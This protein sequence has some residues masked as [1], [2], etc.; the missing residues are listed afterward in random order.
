MTEPVR[1]RP[2]A[3]AGYGYSKKP[4]GMLDWS[5]VEAALA[6]ANVYFLSTIGPDGGPHT[7]PIWGAWV[8][9][10]LYVEGGDDTRWSKNLA[11]NPLLSFGVDAGGLHISGK[12]TAER[13]KAGDSFKNVT[14]NYTSKYSY[15]PQ[16]DEF[17]RLS[18]R[19]VIALNMSSMDA[20][21][22]SPTRFRFPQSDTEMSQRK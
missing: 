1:E 16:R 22:N 20:F 3:P 21:A 5:E 2:V 10:H 9:H 13:A 15:K 19:V 12:G 7:T 4:E 8:G 17:V 6:S 18:P 14:T 11:N